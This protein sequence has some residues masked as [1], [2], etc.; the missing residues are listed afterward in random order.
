MNYPPFVHL[1]TTRRRPRLSYQLLVIALAAVASAAV[2]R[3]VGLFVELAWV[4]QHQ[5]PP[6]ALQCASH[7]IAQLAR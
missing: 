5:E 3:A 4:L 6:G 7:Q 1:A 2:V